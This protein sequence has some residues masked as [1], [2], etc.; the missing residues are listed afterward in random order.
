MLPTG[1]PFLAYIDP[2]SGSML[3]QLV[4]ASFAGSVIYFRDQVAGFFSWIRRKAFTR[5]G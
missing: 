2:G 5:K 4:I 3:V 1:T